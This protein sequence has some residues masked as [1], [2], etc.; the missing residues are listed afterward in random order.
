LSLPEII[1]GAFLEL[2]SI[3]KAALSISFGHAPCSRGASWLW[4]CEQI[5]VVGT[6]F[7]NLAIEFRSN[8]CPLAAFRSR[9]RR[10]WAAQQQRAIFLQGVLGTKGSPRT[11]NEVSARMQ[12]GRG[13]MLLI[14]LT[15]QLARVRA[16]C[17]S[18]YIQ[19][20]ALFF[21]AYT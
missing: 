9:K 12:G 21:I 5:R 14:N 2:F 8:I 19:L 17:K 10:R 4:Q 13:E 6:C 18:A 7:K 11:G 15:H 20:S 1:H 3:Y 16:S